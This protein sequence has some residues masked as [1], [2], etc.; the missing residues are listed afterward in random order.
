MRC[1]Y[2]PHESASGQVDHRDRGVFLVLGVEPPPV[3]GD[4]KAM[5]I[6]RTGLDCADDCVPGEIDERD[7]TTVLASDVEQ[8][9]WPDLQAV[10][11]HVWRKIDVRH[12]AARLKVNDGQQMPGAG[13]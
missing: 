7:H 4:R 10:R 12:M 6:D 13:I 1:R 8:A 3:G 11:R 2:L 9:V 5:R